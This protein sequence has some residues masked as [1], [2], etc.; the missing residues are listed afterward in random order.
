MRIGILTTLHANKFQLDVIESLLHS[1]HKIKAW[2]IDSRLSK[3]HMQKLKDNI[4]K[5]RGGYILIMAL[6]YF[7]K[8]KEASS[9]I[10][11]IMKYSGAPSYFTKNINTAETI[12]KIR[13][14]NTDALVL[15]GGFG[16]IKK[17]IL[18]LCEFG[19]LSYHHGDMKK[20]RGQPPGFWELYN[21]ERYAGVTVQKLNEGLDCGEPLCE[22]SVPINKNDTLNSL[23]KKM[24]SLSS[25]MMLNALD[26]LQ[27]KPSLKMHY[28][29]GKVYTLPDLRRWLLFNL[30]IFFRR[31]NLTR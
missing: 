24:Y 28:E 22:I 13:S 25:D 14:F 4:S 9:D 15:I 7:F 16:I 23:Q 18:D 12:D 20:Y 31:I 5:G 21:N 11:E 30:K 29:Y 1:S 10:S 6:K 8:K 26:Y 17:P 2:V 19:V 3:S 27:T